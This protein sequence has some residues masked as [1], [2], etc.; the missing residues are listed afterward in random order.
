MKTLWK[1]LVVLVL[2]G[3]G[4]YGFYA[5]AGA[6]PNSA[7]GRWYAHWT[8]RKTTGFRT[9][10]VVRQD[11]QASISATGTVEPEETIDVG[12]QVAGQILRFG[13][14]PRNPKKAID[15]G[16]PVEKG[17]ILAVLDPLLYQSRVDQAN[18]SLERSKATLLQMQA[19]YE[20]ASRDWDRAKELGPSRTLTPA[21]VDLA[22]ATFKT[23][24]ANVADA[25]AGIIQAQANLKEAVTNLGYTVIRSPVKGV[26]LDRRVNVGQTVVASLN[27][28]S[29]FLI[30][31]DLRRMQVWASVN[32]ADI[33]NIKPGQKVS[34]TV[35]AYPNH[36]F[37]GNVAP[38][39]P[40]LNASMTQ[41][42]VTYTVVV[43]TDNEDLK[44]KPYLTANLQFEI[45]KR[46]DVLAVPNSALRWRPTQVAE[47]A[48]EEREAY[49]ASMRKK[50]GEKGQ[51][52]ER[53]TDRGIVWVE[54]EGFVRPIKVR[55]G[56]TD[57]AMTEIT[58]GEL[59]VGTNLVVGEIHQGP[60]QENKNPFTPQLFR[61]N[62]NK[63]KDK[64][65]EKDK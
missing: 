29:L 1:V 39:Q 45:A 51:G 48:P 11:I 17:T 65:K 31:K 41:N 42:V 64:D 59:D 28:P 16:T 35:D 22:K 8:G 23:A 10:A 54:E 9:I 40:R 25:R 7:V 61:G 4:A 21:D 34:F 14:D 3:G 18:A 44:L 2:L 55:T 26:I 63:D 56:L 13:P 5:Y 37:L 58:Q 57:G 12:A 6:Q 24:E 46:P 15:Y 19:K 32:E 49:A 33:G 20:Q 62:Q 60:G 36:T 27:A 47:I 52:A 38:D 53:E 50:P 30:A 43:A